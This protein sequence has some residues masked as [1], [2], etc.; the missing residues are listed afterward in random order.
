MYL[1]RSPLQLRTRRE[2]TGAGVQMVCVRRV[3]I[4]QAYW[5]ASEDE[6]KLSELL[7]KSGSLVSSVLMVSRLCRVSR[8]MKACAD[9]ISR[10]GSRV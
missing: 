8:E 10:D 1:E 4:G 5:K 6:E 3:Q 2:E 9:F 7:G